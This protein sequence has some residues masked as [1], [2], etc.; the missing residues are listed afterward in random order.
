MEISSLRW[1]ENGEG[2]MSPTGKIGANV[3]INC[4]HVVE[5]M[6]EWKKWEDEHIDN[7]CGSWEMQ[8]RRTS[9]AGQAGCALHS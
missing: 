2:G 9:P 7:E 5:S 6:S 1:R 3:G 8:I 4:E